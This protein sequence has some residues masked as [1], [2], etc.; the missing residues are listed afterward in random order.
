MHTPFSFTVLT[1]SQQIRYLQLR[2]TYAAART[3][4]EFSYH[5]FSVHSF[6]VELCRE[7]YNGRLMGIYPLPVDLVEAFYA[8]DVSLEVLL[9]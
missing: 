2:G 7:G 8:E 4:G 3:N 6:F 5:L 9:P 1:T